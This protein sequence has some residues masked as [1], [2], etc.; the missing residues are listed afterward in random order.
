MDVG[1]GEGLLAGLGLSDV[2]GIDIRKGKGVD[3]IASAG[4]L[5]FRDEL[6][7][8]VF[9]GE[10]IEHLPEPGHALRDWVRVMSA[11]GTMIISTPNGALVNPIGGNPEHKRIFAPSDIKDAMR[12]L[13]LITSYQK[14]I[15]TG[16]VSGRRLFRWI[17]HD[18]LKMIILR[19]PVPLV[20]SYDIFFR[21]NKR[22]E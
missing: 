5:P 9:A 17:P 4:S 21:A 16:L 11:G 22:P 14:G 20:L 10:V 1:C 19:F 2:V 12:G 15:F 13:G 6:F 3:V 7:E 8:L 18:K